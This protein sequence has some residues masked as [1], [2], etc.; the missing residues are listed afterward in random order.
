MQ[1][2]LAQR[3]KQQQQKA[4]KTICITKY[5]KVKSKMNQEENE[6]RGVERRRNS[7]YTGINLGQYP[8]ENEEKDRDKKGKGISKELTSF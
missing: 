1:K 8:V 3:P 2:L 7:G 4:E 5:T 6:Q